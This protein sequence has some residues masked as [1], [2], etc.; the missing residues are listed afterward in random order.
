MRRNYGL[1]DWMLVFK[2]RIALI[3]SCTVICGLMALLCGIF[4]VDDIY[5]AK[6]LLYIGRDLGSVNDE[7]DEQYHDALLSSMMAKD[8]KRMIV[9]YDV[10]E[11]VLDK[12]HYDDMSV[13]DLSKKLK[14]LNV[15]D[16]RIIEIVA[17]DENPHN[18][19]RISNEVANAFIEDVGG[20]LSIK[21]ISII[22]QA[23]APK[24]PVNSS[25][26]IDFAAIG[27]L[28]GMLFG[29][30][31]VAC[32]QVFGDRICDPREASE[33]LNLEIVG[34]IGRFGDKTLEK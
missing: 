7:I 14:I 27:M 21:N 32:G 10:S 23:R 25:R 19:A 5:E 15:G 24:S 13:D 20:T 28:I 6:T 16:T 17:Q 31:F 33:R 1:R 34:V 29:L 2:R 22:E 8:Y 26:Y 9:G 11:S 4:A 18:A 30:V 12:L 3:A